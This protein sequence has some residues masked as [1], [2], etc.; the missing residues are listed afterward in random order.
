MNEFNPDRQIAIIWSIEDVQ[1]IRPDLDDEQSMVVLGTVENKHDASIGVNWDTL[2]I[3]ADYH[4][5]LEEI[6]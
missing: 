6:D 5:P 1:S 3:W 2:Q 4:Y